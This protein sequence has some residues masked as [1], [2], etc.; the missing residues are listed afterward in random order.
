M[1]CKIFGES[2]TLLKTQG[3][4]DQIPRVGDYIELDT[5][6]DYL[7]DTFD[8][9]QVLTVTWREHYHPPEVVV[10]YLKQVTRS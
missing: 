8:L 3:F 4:S 6:N 9:Y 2:G 1:A 7:V 5:H 10:R